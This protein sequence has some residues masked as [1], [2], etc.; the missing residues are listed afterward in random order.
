MGKE[1]EKLKGAYKAAGK[2]TDVA[3]DR[4]KK[5]ELDVLT[6]AVEDPSWGSG[7]PK[8]DAKAYAKALEE[9]GILAKQHSDALDVFQA[10]TTRY[11]DFCDKKAKMNKA[12]KAVNAVKQKFR[13]VFGKI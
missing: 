9:Y 12:E 7:D 11:N 1:R 3:Y 13:R 4:M 5:K 2:A 10:A 8:A 6:Q